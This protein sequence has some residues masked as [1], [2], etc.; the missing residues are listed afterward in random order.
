[1]GKIS[2]WVVIVFLLFLGAYALQRVWHP[3]LE[4]KI[5]VLAFAGSSW[6]SWLISHVESVILKRLDKIDE[7]LIDIEQRLAAMED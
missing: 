2:F 3:S 4:E 7:K 6:V 5:M 1:M